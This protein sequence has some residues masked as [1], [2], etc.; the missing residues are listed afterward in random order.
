LDEDAVVL[1]FP[2]NG[3]STE[4]SEIVWSISHHDLR[5]QTDE[6]LAFYLAGLLSRHEG[7]QCIYG[8]LLRGVSVSG[9]N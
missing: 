3:H 8:A 6:V 2:K 7:A 9:K 4:I 1:L 5:D